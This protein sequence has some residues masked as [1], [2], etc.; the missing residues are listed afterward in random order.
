MTKKEFLE[1]LSNAIQ[2]DYILKEDQDLNKIE[3]YDSLAL[4]SISALFSEHFNLEIEGNILRNC[5]NVSDLIAL[6][7]DYI[8]D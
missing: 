2:L 3:E 5:Q 4:L 7:K 6:A 1:E 8:K